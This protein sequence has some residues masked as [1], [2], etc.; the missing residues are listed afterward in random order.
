M[1]EEN[2]VY[3]EHSVTFAVVLC[4]PETVLLGYAVGTAGRTGRLLLRH[5]LH[6][7]EQF[8]GRCLIYP[9]FLFQTE[10]AYSFEHAQRTL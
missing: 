7:A 10:N 2:A 6:L 3:G 4:N 9:G 5:F 1:V 8:R